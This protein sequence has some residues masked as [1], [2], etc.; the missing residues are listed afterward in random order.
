MQTQGTALPPL[1]DQAKAERRE[2]VEAFAE[3]VRRHLTNGSFAT[4]AEA[5]VDL[6]H[7]AWEVGGMVRYVL[8]TLAEDL[9]E[10]E[11]RLLCQGWFS[12]TLDEIGEQDALKEFERSGVDRLASRAREL[13][14]L[15]MTAQRELDKVILRNEPLQGDATKVQLTLE[16]LDAE[17]RGDRR[18]TRKAL[19]AFDEQAG[20]LGA[21]WRLEL[22][23]ARRDRDRRAVLFAQQPA[24]AAPAA[25]VQAAPQAAAQEAAPAQ[26]APAAPVQAPVAKP[27]V[28]VPAAPVEEAPVAEPTVEASAAPVEEATAEATVEA[29]PAAEPELL[30]Q[31]PPARVESVLI[32]HGDHCECGVCGFGEDP[33]AAALQGMVPLTA[34]AKKCPQC[35]VRFT[36]RED[37]STRLAQ[38]PVE[39]N[40]S[41]PFVTA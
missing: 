32:V 7:L 29:Q 11:A 25:P 23:R 27:T 31:E 18:G 33:E 16:V 13:N 35:T 4:L 17:D 30:V 36:R 40:S 8:G 2:R 28:A 6:D 15:C 5:D 21:M 20:P 19:R 26:A 3:I 12:R 38:V 10:D 41:T 14:E 22:G 37:R 1:D 39:D 34:D 9:G 24:A